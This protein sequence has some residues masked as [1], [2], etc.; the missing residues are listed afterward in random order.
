MT[1]GLAIE[2][3]DLNSALR[4]G[5]RLRCPRC[6]EGRLFRGYIRVAGGCDCCGLDFSPQRAD[7]GPAYLVIL[8]V[9][10]IVGFTL[11]VMFGYM[12]DNPL[13]LALTMSTMATVLALA[14]LPPIKGAF[15]AL[16]WSKGMHGF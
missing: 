4:R 10:H 12:R 7:D 16:Q 3:R 14:L 6:G 11:P 8:I 13:L 5:A 15:I 1:T 9:C 2:D